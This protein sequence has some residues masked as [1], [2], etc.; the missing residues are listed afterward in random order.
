MIVIT[1]PTGAIGHQV[2]TNV[3]AGDQPVR[4]IVR[5]PTRLPASVR[6]RVE[7][8]K[9]SHGDPHVVAE[10]FDG[11]DTLFWLL[12]TDNHAASVDDA[13]V[14]FTRPA[15]EAI[16]NQGVRHVVD[17]TA[18]GRTTAYAGQAGHVTASL[19]MDDLIASTG[20]AFRALACPSFMDN[21]LRQAAV[22]K[23]QGAFFDMLAPDHAAPAI[24]TR[25]IAAVAGRLLLDSTWTG[26]EEVQLLGPE[27]LS[28]SEMAAVM[29]DVLGTPVRYQQITGQARKDQ[30]T[31]Y[32]MA[33]A[34]AQGLVDMLT[35]KDNGL[36]AGIARTPQH[37]ADTP[38][39]FRQWCEDALKP[40]VQA[41]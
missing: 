17:V 31:G 23:R 11:A 37:T 29:S 8:V 1:T 7:V 20:V 6:D 40:A 22:I 34:M 3:L 9:G 10:A 2:L 24:A 27:D 4:V 28:P 14:G 30:L 38:T 16:R 41:A 18:L 12:P 32:G 13:Y 19:A 21:M 35:A 36:D 5:D 33:D 39:T 25:D 26:Q 15:A